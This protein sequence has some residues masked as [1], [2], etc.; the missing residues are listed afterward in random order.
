MTYSAMG[1]GVEVD[2]G[3]TDDRSLVKVDG[4][5]CRHPRSLPTE[6]WKLRSL[7]V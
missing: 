4:A 3:N 2:L 1:E 6:Y 7:E 5:N